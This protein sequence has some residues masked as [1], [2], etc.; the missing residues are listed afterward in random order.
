MATDEDGNASS[1]DAHALLVDPEGHPSKKIEEVAVVNP[2]AGGSPSFTPEPSKDVLD[3]GI[4][5]SRGQSI[6]TVT[7]QQSDSGSVH[8]IPAVRVTESPAPILDEPQS[9]LPSPTPSV[10]S[11]RPPP[12]PARSNTLQE[13]SSSGS[14]S[15]R[16]MGRRSTIEVGF[17]L[18]CSGRRV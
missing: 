8:S 15:Q 1:S 5:S 16:R 18:L 11:N 13:P 2:I 14:V 3:S 7:D 6:S 4:E 10:L 17:L 12:S 9:V